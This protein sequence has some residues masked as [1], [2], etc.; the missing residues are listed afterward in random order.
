[1]TTARAPFSFTMHLEECVQ[2]RTH[3][4]ALCN[5]GIIALRVS[6]IEHAIFKHAMPMIHPRRLT[7]VRVTQRKRCCHCTRPII[8]W[9]YHYPISDELAHVPCVS[10]VS[11]DVMD[12][13]MMKRNA[14]TSLDVRFPLPL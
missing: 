3:P 10:F 1:M 9:A 14:S 5:I 4:F 13:L 7:W 6:A 2:C 12:M 11:C 8:S